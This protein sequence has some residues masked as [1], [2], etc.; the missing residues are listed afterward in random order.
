MVRQLEMIGSCEDCIFEKMYAWAYD[1]KVVT[2]EKILL[3]CVHVD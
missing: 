2:H 1:D 3:E